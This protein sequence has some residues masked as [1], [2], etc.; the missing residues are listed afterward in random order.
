VRRFADGFPEQ[1]L[2]TLAAGGSATLRIRPDRAE[3][4]WHVRVAS[5]RRVTAC[6]LA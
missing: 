2:G 6:G 3:Q 1:P 5:D 4:P